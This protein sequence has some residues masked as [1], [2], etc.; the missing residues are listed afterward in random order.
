MNS[1]GGK[2]RGISRNIYIMPFLPTNELLLG[3]IYPI[4]I[5]IMAFQVNNVNIFTFVQS[6]LSEE[7]EGFP[8]KVLQSIIARIFIINHVLLSW[9]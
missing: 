4:E 8:E 6:V 3:L 1:V 2:N 9:K 7:T 5:Y